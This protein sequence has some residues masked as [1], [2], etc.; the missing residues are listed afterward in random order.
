MIGKL[1]LRAIQSF[2][3]AMIVAGFTVSVLRFSGM[4]F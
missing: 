4:N 2:G 3:Y 1:M